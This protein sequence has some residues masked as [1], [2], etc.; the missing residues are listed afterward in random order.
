MAKGTGCRVTEQAWQQALVWL[1]RY[2]E[3]AQV[4]EQLQHSYTDRAGMVGGM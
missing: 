3:V 4:H 2:R 1:T